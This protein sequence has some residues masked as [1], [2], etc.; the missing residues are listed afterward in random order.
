RRLSRWRRLHAAPLR[1]EQP[2]EQ[3]RLLPARGVGPH[4]REDARA[5]AGVRRA[6][7]ALSAALA[8]G[9]GQRRLEAARHALPQHAG[10]AAG[11]RTPETPYLA[12]SFLVLGCE[13]R[14]PQTMSARRALAPADNRRSMVA[15]T[16]T[17]DRR[18]RR[19]SR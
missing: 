2:P 12:R 11:D 8:H 9:R 3:H 19:R 6:Q 16:M 17:A 5:A 7:P 4:L 15:A 10:P 14:P 13:Q 1:A 18:G